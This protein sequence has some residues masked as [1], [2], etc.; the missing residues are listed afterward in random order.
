MSLAF[1]HIKEKIWSLLSTIE[2]PEIPVLSI[3]DIG[4]VRDVI[5]NE[6][7]VEIK[8]TPTYSGC[9][10]MNLFKEQ[11]I[12]KLSESGYIN[13][14][15]TVVY[16]PVWTSE[17]IGEE[18]KL[19]LKEYGIAPPEKSVREICCPLCDSDI[20]ELISNFGSTACKALYKCKSCLEPFEYFKCI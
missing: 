11:I 12:I 5:V 19:K 18:S 14:K 8:I 9:P 17:C 13:V 20:T 15:I 10:A 7:S 16:T 2:D 1:E 3:V 4:V 6:N